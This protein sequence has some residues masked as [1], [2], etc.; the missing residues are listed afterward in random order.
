MNI[1]YVYREWFH[2]FKVFGKI[3]HEL[4]HNVVCRELN[5]NKVT[6]KDVGKCEIIWVHKPQF[7][8]YI[9]DNNKLV[10]TYNPVIKEDRDKLVDL[11][12]P[13]GVVFIPNKHEVEIMQ[14]LSGESKFK[15]M[16]WGYDERRYYPQFIEK[17]IDFSYA[18]SA[19]KNE[20]RVEWFKKMKELLPSILFFGKQVCE[21]TKSKK[22]LYSS[23][24][25]QRRIYQATKCNID[26]PLTNKRRDFIPYQ[27]MRFF[28]IPACGEILLTHYSD[29]FAELFEPDKEMFYYK[30][31]DEFI[32]KAKWIVKNYDNLMHVRIS[33]WERANKDHRFE[34]RF[35]TMLE[36]IGEML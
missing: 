30:D 5:N 34:I 25:E 4:G 31:I 9:P 3:M 18:G 24:K 17:S 28:E 23:H 27:K 32:S 29:E 19:S 11:Y 10:V 7:L 15:Y 12:K 36:I 26:C 21:V 16:P 8:K 2:R 20:V 14:K 35:K 33:A 6:K 22:R 1:L 13:F